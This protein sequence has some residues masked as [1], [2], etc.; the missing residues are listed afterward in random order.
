MMTPQGL[1][2]DSSDDSF[3]RLRIFTDG[4]VCVYIV[5]RVRSADRRSV[6]VRVKSIT[7]L[8]V[9]HELP[10]N[11]GLELMIICPAGGLFRRFYEFQHGQSSPFLVPKITRELARCRRALR[12]R[13]GG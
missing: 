4:I 3:T 5:F 12:E 6:P 8:I 2:I 10:P 1:Q 7:N 9:L 11:F 13:A